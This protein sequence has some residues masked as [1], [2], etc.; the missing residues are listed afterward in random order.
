MGSSAGAK[1]PCLGSG[2]TTGAEEIGSGWAQR[3]PH[4]SSEATWPAGLPGEPAPASWY[5]DAAERPARLR[6]CVA[7]AAGASVGRV[8]ETPISPAAGSLQRGR[9]GGARRRASRCSR[10]VLPRLRSGDRDFRQGGA[11]GGSALPPGAP[12]PTA[13]P[14]G[15]ARQ[16]VATKQLDNCKWIHIL[17]LSDL[18]PKRARSAGGPRDVGRNRSGNGLL[19][20]YLYAQWAGGRGRGRRGPLQRVTALVMNVG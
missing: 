5:A 4:R 19:L 2:V 15:G 18:Q 8:R 3:V 11:A 16:Q 7:A 6:R 13:K 12:G 10:R 1:V 14:A 20:E 17:D 9:E